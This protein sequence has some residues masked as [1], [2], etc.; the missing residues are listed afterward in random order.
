MKILL[1]SSDYTDVLI[2]K[3][4]LEQE[5]FLVHMDNFEAGSVMPHLALSL[6]FRLWVPDEQHEEAL[7]VL[8]EA[9]VTAVAGNTDAVDAIDTCPACGSEDAVRYHSALWL[10]PLAMLQL[11][12]P[13]PRGNRRKCLECGA[14][15]KTS[16]PDIPGSLAFLFAFIAALA[17]FALLSLL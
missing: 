12:M 13:A 3:A 1:E 16:D 8:R 10:L 17:V 15:Y 9:E 11:F 5:G 4:L 2:K 7:A 14:K 6:G